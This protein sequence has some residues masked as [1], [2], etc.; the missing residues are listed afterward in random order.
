MNFVPGGSRGDTLKSNFPPRKAC[1]DNFVL[2]L[3]DLSICN[4]K[5]AWSRRRSHLEMGKFGSNE[6][7]LYLK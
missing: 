2:Y 7:N 3:A 1:T 6:T 4:V 5:N